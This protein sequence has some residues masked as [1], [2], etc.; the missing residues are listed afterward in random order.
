MAGRL[1]AEALAAHQI[2]LNC[3][4]TTFMVPLGMSAAAAVA[5]GHAIG[6][7]DLPR[8]RRAGWL[9]LGSGAAFMGLAA[10]AFLLLPR[11]LLHIYTQDETVVV[12]G[13]RLL[14]LAAAFQIFDG[15]QTVA[16]GALRGAGET[17][18]PMFVNLGGY[19]LFGLPLGY[20]LCFQAQRGVFGIWIGLTI[21]LI[22]IALCLLWQWGRKS[23]RMMLRAT[24]SQLAAQP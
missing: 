5:V 4:S 12:L 22:I 15:I 20:A 24:G 1:D 19:W 11:P 8:A 23:H 16:T 6:A 10:C 14:M 7:G 13:T 9:A 18:Q 2:V 3:A 21:S 17:R